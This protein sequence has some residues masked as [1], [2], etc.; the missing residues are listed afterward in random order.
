MLGLLP[1]PGGLICFQQKQ[2]DKKHVRCF[3]S[4]MQPVNLLSMET[5]EGSTDRPAARAVPP[6]EL[7]VV[8]GNRALDLCNSR[9]GP[10]DGGTDIDGLTR[11]D[12]VVPWA[13]HAGVITSDEAAAVS[14]SDDPELAESVHAQLS[15]LRDDAHAVF[16]A[17][18][19]GVE[20]P[21]RALDDLRLADRRARDRA[22][23]VRHGD[24]YTSTWPVSDR[25]AIVDRVAHAASTLL[26]NGPLSRVR[27][28]A[29][30][31]F[32]FLDESKNGSRRWCSM[33][34]C[35]R[36]EK[37]RLYVERRRSRTKAAAAT[38]Q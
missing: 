26:D 3:S 13:V 32:L 19:A 2:F 35:G 20:P 30:C 25:T 5:F 38:K 33:D 21:L 37:M 14:E 27:Q 9:S 8:G 17:I 11:A 22:R 4:W 31:S 18:A 24:G 1:V 34:D 12:D 23:Y 16:H 29:G 15:A 10:H 28:C 7:R 6:V 36:E